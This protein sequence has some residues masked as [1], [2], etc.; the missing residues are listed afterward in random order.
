[1][2]IFFVIETTQSEGAG[3]MRFEVTD[4]TAPFQ[5]PA[6]QLGKNLEMTRSIDE[7]R[8][9]RGEKGQ[10]NCHRVSISN[11]WALKTRCAL[12]TVSLAEQLADGD[13]RLA[14]VILPFGDRIRD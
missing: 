4:D 12:D 9:G 13:L 7:S 3:D 8:A 11:R 10:L 5:F 1:M 2:R 6:Q 14:R